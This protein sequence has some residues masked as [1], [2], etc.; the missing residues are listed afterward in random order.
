MLQDSV[1]KIF[2]V[3]E[4]RKRVLFTLGML[5]VFD[6]DLSGSFAIHLAAAG[7]VER[8]ADGGRR[9]I[10]TTFARAKAKKADT[11]SATDNETHNETW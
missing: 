1:K 2:A 10:W 7:G 6:H 3:P 11:V 4:L 5:A 9:R 8:P